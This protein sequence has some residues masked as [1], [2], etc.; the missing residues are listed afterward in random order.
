M[1][2]ATILIPGS[3]IVAAFGT[4]KSELASALGL[5]LLTWAMFTAILAV[6][7]LG[8]NYGFVSLFSLLTI[9]FVVLAC[10]EFG[11]NAKYVVS[12]FSSTIDLN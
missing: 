4:N 12:I 8:K 1:S 11:G 10:G 6:T 5:F 2:Y 9:T 3:G 7:S